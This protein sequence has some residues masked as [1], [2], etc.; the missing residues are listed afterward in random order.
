MTT[1]K[2]YLKALSEHTASVLGGGVKDDPETDTRDTILFVGGGM[3][4]ADALIV[5]FTGN[6]GV[7]KFLGYLLAAGVV[8][9]IL[10]APL[11]LVMHFISKGHDPSENYGRKIG[12]EKDTL[13]PYPGWGS[14]A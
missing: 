12:Q 3:A 6:L 11:F 14:H 8:L 9:A 1:K 2:G 13:P 5:L 10:A 4:V 7:L